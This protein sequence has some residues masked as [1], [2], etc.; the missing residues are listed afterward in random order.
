VLRRD[1]V[2]LI[3]GGIGITPIRAL[4]EHMSGDLV[5]VYRVMC[6]ADLIFRDELEALARSR[7]V[8]LCYVVGDHAAPGAEHLLS[9]EHLCQLIPD[10]ADR[11]VFLC[12]PPA[13]MDVLEQNVRRTGVP[14]KYIH[15]ER[16]A[17]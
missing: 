13:M 17:L 16:F 11:D 12:G 3:A 9:P 4:I 6:D 8:R 14:S 5:L 1:R 2:A 15:S 10:I 7:C